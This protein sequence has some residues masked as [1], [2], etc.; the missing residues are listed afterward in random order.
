MAIR[1]VRGATTVEED[2]PG[3]ILLATRE[4]LKQ[5]MKENAAM[6]IED[7]A[8]A[9]FTVT[10]DLSSAYPALGARQMGWKDVPMLCSR[11][12][13]VPASL[14]RVVRVLIHWNTDLHQSAMRHVYLHDAV[15]L[16]PDLSE[17]AAL[18]GV[19]ENQP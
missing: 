10:E 6:R 13:P 5:L 1:G 2:E 3:A 15:M 14:P 11:E 18:S 12:I 7:I 17:R 4:L 9:L 8:S 19:Q 16:R